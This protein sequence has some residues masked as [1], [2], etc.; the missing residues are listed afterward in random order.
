MNSNR[1][2]I[3]LT[4]VLLFFGVLITLMAATGG[5]VYYKRKKEPNGGIWNV[6]SRNPEYIDTV[7]F[8]FLKNAF[9]WNFFQF[10]MHYNF[11]LIR[12]I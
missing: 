7:R 8:M 3:I 12:K 11:I 4:V 6:S 9:V 1:S 2:G 10:E 5:Y